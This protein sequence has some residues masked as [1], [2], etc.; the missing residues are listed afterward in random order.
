MATLLIG[1]MTILRILSS[2]IDLVT[3]HTGHFAN[4]GLSGGNLAYMLS[5]LFAIFE[6]SSGK[7]DEGLSGHF[8]NIGLSGG[9]LA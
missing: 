1:S 8:V 4:I 6:L 7:V 3:R 9:N 5:V 2:V